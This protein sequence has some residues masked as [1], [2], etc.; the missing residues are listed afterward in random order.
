MNVKSA[1]ITTGINLGNLLS[2]LSVALDFNHTGLARHHRRVAHVALKI[3]RALALPDEDLRQLYCSA[4]LHDIGAVSI[5]EKIALAEFEVEDSFGHCTRGREFVTDTYL[6]APLGDVIACHH[7]HWSGNN[8]SGFSREEIPLFSRIIH[9][10]DR[11][12]VG[13][14]AGAGDILERRDS[15]FDQFRRLSGKIFDPRL[16]EVLGDISIRESFW[17]DLEA[18]FLPDLLQEQVGDLVTIVGPEDLLGIARMFSRVIDA[19]SAFTYRHS[20]LVTAIA[21][22]L[23]GQLGFSEPQLQEMKVAGLLHD[24]GKLSIPEQI[25]EKPGK[26]S[27]A[28]YNIIK[29]HPYYTYHILRPI[30]GFETIRECAAYHHERLDG[31]GYP[32]GITAADLTLGARVVTVADIFAALVEDRP[33]RPGMTREQ[34]TAIFERQTNAGA[35]DPYVVSTLLR[36][37]TDFEALK[38]SR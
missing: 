17:L 7:D 3:G 18:S 38:S 19:K 13:L 12:D 16:V 27:P 30:E 32:F 10:A 21:V 28:E 4:L 34:V 5:W 29:R 1:G 36:N 14:E 23:A 35:L 24:L 25:L 2:S 22:Q 9:L 33:Y 20:A 37:Y 6:F 8:P 31:R 11:L 26:L 15:M